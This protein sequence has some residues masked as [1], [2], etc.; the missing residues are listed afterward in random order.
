MERQRRRTLLLVLALP[1][2]L[3]LAILVLYG[4]CWWIAASGRP[5]RS[6][7]AR[8]LA[9]GIAY[10]RMVWDEPRPILWHIVTVD[11]ERYELITTPR[12]PDGPLDVLA[13]KTSE[14]AELYGAVVAL[15]GSYFEP[16]HTRHYFDYY[17]RTGDPVDLL[18]RCL[19]Q[20]QIV[21]ADH[22][23]YPVIAWDGERAAIF[24]GGVPTGEHMVMAGAQIL[25]RDGQLAWGFMEE[26][27]MPRIGLGMRNRG[28]TLVIVAADGRQ[29]GYSEGVTF[30]ELAHMLVSR[31]VEAGMA[32]D[33]GG[34]TTLVARDEEGR[35]DILN[36]PYHTGFPMRERPVGNHLGIRPR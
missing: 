5:L 4:A 19:A 7:T 27:V 3:A 1:L 12:H 17:P 23:A 10:E 34:S 15:N 24:E 30:L 21:S 29:P 22:A 18:G 11:L 14:F 9:T 33:G 8:T 36:A 35:V 13:R 16:V 31:R 20:G 25:V 26:R 6:E 32:L 28:R 2:L